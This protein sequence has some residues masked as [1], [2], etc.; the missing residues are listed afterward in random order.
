M[1]NQN[2]I[3]D[4]VYIG[5]YNKSEKLSGPEKTAKR[6]FTLSAQKYNTVFIQYFFDGNK[7]S[8]SRK[9]FGLEESVTQD[10][11]KIYTSGLLRLFI[12]LFK[13]KPKLIHII[14][15]E[16]FASFAVYYA[17]LKKIKTIYNSHGIITHEDSYI[18]HENAG[19]SS[20]NRKVEKILLEKC[21]IIVFPSEAAKA[22]CGKYYNMEN[23]IMH[24]I[25]NGIDAIFHLPVEKYSRDAVVFFAGNELHTSGRDFLKKFLAEPHTGLNLYI[26]GDKNYFS[27][28]NDFGIFKFDIM[29]SI[30][31]AEF[32]KNK[33]IFLSINEYD[34]FSISTAEAMASG[35]IPIVTKQTGISSM[36]FNDVNGYVIDF[37]DVE[38]LKKAIG[39]LR[40][41]SKQNKEIIRNNSKSIYHKLKWEKIFELYERI[42]S[43]GKQQ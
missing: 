35:L 26:I 7:Y 40:I 42:Y 27:A 20:R 43:I 13:L 10:N 6:I 25:P 16:R 33:D 22:H 12:L 14:T 2:S 19:Y 37:G 41:M 18:K 39:K 15:F 36:I 34:T 38:Q 28:Y 5:R 30:K 1:K 31:L 32:Y 17:R 3:I 8:L 9:L 24:I 29:E 21:S 23:A 11:Q 4:I